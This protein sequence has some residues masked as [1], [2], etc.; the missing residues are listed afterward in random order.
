MSSPQRSWSETTI[1]CASE[2]CSR[3]HGFIIAVSSGRP[4]RFSVYHRGRGHEPVTVAGSSRSFVAV[5]AMQ[6]LLRLFVGSSHPRGHD[7]TEGEMPT[8]RNG[9]GYG[10]SGRRGEGGVG[11]GGRGRGL[12]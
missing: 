10:G 8:M 11:G 12:P 4:Q 6:S 7:E 5:N 2:N 1:A 9:D 3:N